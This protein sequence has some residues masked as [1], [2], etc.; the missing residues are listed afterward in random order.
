MPSISY[1]NSSFGLYGNNF[2]EFGVGML[3]VIKG[4]IGITN[5]PTLTKISLPSLLSVGSL[6]I[7]NNTKVKI[8]NGFTQLGTT[9]GSLNLTGN[10]SKYGL[11]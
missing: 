6:R 2:K 4:S 5:N 8:I 3:G 10:F 1:T 11:L 9:S 7:G